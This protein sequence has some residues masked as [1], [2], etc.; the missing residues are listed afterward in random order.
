MSRQ[1]RKKLSKYLK[2]RA[3]QPIKL[4]TTSNINKEKFKP[5]P[6]MG[7]KKARRIASIKKEK[8]K[9]L[10]AK[11]ILTLSTIFQLGFWILCIALDST[12][13]GFNLKNKATLNSDEYKA[14]NQ[15]HKLQVI[16]ERL[17]AGEFA[18]T[19]QLVD[20]IDD[21]ENYD[22]KQFF[23]ETA[24]SEQ[25]EAYA[26]REKTADI[27]IVA[28]TSFWAAGNTAYLVNQYADKKIRKRER[29][30]EELAEK[31]DY[32]EK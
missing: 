14:F 6:M 16:E 28:G 4:N 32:V 18:T 20:A 8:K 25:K 2:K 10:K 15:Q 27:S 29:E 30:V 23:D 3:K 11:R 22:K 19:S 17:D 1:K 13:I 31:C 12:S 21:I 5:A 9:I 24:S 26:S 7:T